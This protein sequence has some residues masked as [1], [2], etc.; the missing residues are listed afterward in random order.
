[1]N[2]GYI[3]LRNFINEELAARMNENI[4]DD[5]KVNYK[6]YDIVIDDI[7]KKLDYD[8]N[9]KSTYNKYRV[10]EGKIK[11]TSNST[12]ASNY[13]RD[14]GIFDNT[15]IVPEIYTLVIYLDKSTLQLIPDSY[16]TFNYSDL[17]NEID[18]H[19]NPGDAIL[20]N[21]L[22][23]HRGK[24]ENESDSKTRKCIQVFEVFKNDEDYN[25]YNSKTLTIPSI[26]VE[27]Y[28]IANLAQNYF[29]KNK[30]LREYSK[31]KGLQSFCIKKKS[32]SDDFY[33]FSSEAER[34]RTYRD[35]DLGNLYRNTNTTFDIKNNN[36][37]FYKLIIRDFLINVAYD[38]LI[39]VFIIFIIVILVKYKGKNRFSKNRF[40]KIIKSI[41]NRVNKI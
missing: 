16:K 22:T 38:I 10:S 13:H 39:V 15:D 1:M 26:D 34:K 30:M 17:K 41:Q 5:N 18:I 12:D 37:I 35:I 21:A 25:N 36:D 32:I 3:L 2:D 28:D 7:L 27:Q 6:N 40:S 19:F 20:F 29:L 31:V 11:Q 9:W 8:M 33:Y 23:L 14:V 24:Y 4:L